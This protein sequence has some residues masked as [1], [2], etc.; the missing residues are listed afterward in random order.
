MACISGSVAILVGHDDDV[1]LDARLEKSGALNRPRGAAP[2]TSRWAGMQSDLAIAAA[3]AADFPHLRTT[4][5]H[6]VDELLATE[7][8]VVIVLSYRTSPSFA[9]Y[10]KFFAALRALEARGTA[11]YPSADFKQLISSKAE[12]ARVLQA[13]GLPLCSTEVVDRAD[14]VD[15]AGELVPALVEARLQAAL[16]TLGLLPPGG[17]AAAGAAAAAAPFKLVSKPSNADGGFGVAFWESDGLAEPA[18][19]AAAAVP[20]THENVDAQHRS[21]AAAAE[22]A[23]GE[24]KEPKEGKARPPAARLTDSLRLSAMLTAGAGT[25]SLPEPA[26]LAASARPAAPFVRY[27]SEVAFAARRPHCLLQPLVPLLGQH[28]EIK[29]YFLK[30]EV[31]YAS[32]VYGGH[33]R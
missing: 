28:F 31:F 26:P 25:T 7:A 12:Y 23:A 15:E 18:A 24:P 1:V 6:S 13:A 30:R 2:R 17:G 4:L 16:R 8:E 29:I 19:A 11:V 10:E 14:C 3:I 33:F 21:A 9:W 5:L 27:L 22:G 20:P 32:L